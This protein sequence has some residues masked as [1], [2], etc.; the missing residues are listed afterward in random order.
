MAPNSF[1][2]R[3]CARPCTIPLA[4]S[5]DYF[6]DRADALARFAYAY[7]SKRAT[8]LALDLL[9]L[10]GAVASLEGVRRW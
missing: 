4:P 2:L 5:S 8:L 7:A 1:S 10:A 3:E 9:T 6:R